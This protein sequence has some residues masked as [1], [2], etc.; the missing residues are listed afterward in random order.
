MSNTQ[1]KKFSSVFALQEFTTKVTKG[2]LLLL[3]KSKNS[4]KFL[5]TTLLKRM[6]IILLF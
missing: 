2:L 6:K 1:V 5:E 4:C 3:Q